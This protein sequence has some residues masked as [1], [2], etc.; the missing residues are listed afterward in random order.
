MPKIAETTT[1]TSSKAA[2]GRRRGGLDRTR[3]P[4]L[5]LDQAL[6]RKQTPSRKLAG[7]IKAWMWVRATITPARSASQAST[8]SQ[9][10][11]CL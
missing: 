5:A 4:R 10:V 7:A 11:R 2:L 9:V 1:L 6:T 3:R 8:L